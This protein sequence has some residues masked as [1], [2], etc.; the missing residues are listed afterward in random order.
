[1]SVQKVTVSAEEEGQR[2]DRWF[3]A[4]FPQV[5]HGRLEKL[6]RK[7]EIRVNGGR[8][9]ANLRLESGM[10]VR[11]P[12]LPAPDQMTDPSPVPESDIAALRE[13]ILYRDDILV[14]IDKPAGLAVQGG[15]G[16]TRHLDGMLDGLQF[17]APDRPRLVHRLDRD[18]SGVL[19]LARTRSAA[20][21]LTETFA[22]RSARKTYWAVVHGS[23]EADEGRLESTLSK[24]PSSGGR[25]QM[26]SDPGGK[27]ATTLYKVVAGSEEPFTWLE[28]TPLTGRTHQIRVQTAEA[29]FPVVGDP[30]YGHRESKSPSNALGRG[31]HLHARAL[32]IPHPDG[33]TLCVDAPLPSHMSQSWQAL[34]WDEP[35]VPPPQRKM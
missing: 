29:G 3:R 7:G 24:V 27:P 10:V 21:Q 28:L 2:L 34:G 26:A 22:D 1:M 11:V 6:L 9:R 5:T 16:T 25:E 30:R 15:S 8:V 12:P 33:G 4:K 20:A 17:D 32:E 31:L 18:T 23:P 35:P 14:A 19:V 13:R